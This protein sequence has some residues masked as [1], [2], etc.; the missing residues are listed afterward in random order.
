[1]IARMEDG[2][3]KDHPGASGN[4]RVDLPFHIIAPE[5]ESTITKTGWVLLV[6][7]IWGVLLY[8][9]LGSSKP[10]PPS[11]RGKDQMTAILT[12]WRDEEYAVALAE[13]EIWQ[14]VFTRKGDPE[15]AGQKH[16]WLIVQRNENNARLIQRLSRLTH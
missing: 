12:E 10:A 4:C 14:D 13:N 2:N 9:V 6:V 8:I 5:R 7:S 1:M 15:K 3:G 11:D 16:G